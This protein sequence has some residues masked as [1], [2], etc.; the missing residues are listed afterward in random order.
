MSRKVG[1]TLLY[2]FLNT[3][4]ALLNNR[5]VTSWRICYEW[6]DQKINIEVTC[7]IKKWNVNN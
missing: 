2:I 7:E 6:N 5:W 4:K 3:A 1:Q